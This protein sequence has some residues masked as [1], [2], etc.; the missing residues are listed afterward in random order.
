MIAVSDPRVKHVSVLF[1]D[2]GTAINH[3]QRMGTLIHN[4]CDAI[5]HIVKLDDL[6]SSP[7]YTVIALGE[8]THIPPTQLLLRMQM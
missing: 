1:A 2:V 5:W 6:Q 8:H 4:K 3:L 7:Y